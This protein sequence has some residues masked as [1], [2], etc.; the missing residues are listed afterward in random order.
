MD[1]QSLKL[2][3]DITQTRSFIRTAEKNYMSASTLSRHIQRMEQEIGQPLF[4]RDNRQ[5]ILTEAGERFSHFAEQTW[6]EW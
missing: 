5:V 2:F 6:A 4:L 3:L 1:L